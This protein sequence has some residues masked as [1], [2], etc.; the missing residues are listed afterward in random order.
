MTRQ[1][2]VPAQSPVAVAAFPPVGNHWYVKGGLPPLT[3]TV[4]VPVHEPHTSGVDEFV[5]VNPVAHDRKSM[6]T[7]ESSAQS[8]ASAIAILK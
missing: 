5:C 2:Y 8:L 7:P 4:A 3:L 6:N 1:L